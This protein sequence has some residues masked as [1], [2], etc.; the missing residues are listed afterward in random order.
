MFAPVHISPDSGPTF[1]LLPWHSLNF[2]MVSE[3]LPEKVAWNY[4]SYK[5]LYYL[6]LFLCQINEKEI[7]FFLSG[8]T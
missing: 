8:L 2:F 5:S 4:K 6:V 3:S 1:S 7:I